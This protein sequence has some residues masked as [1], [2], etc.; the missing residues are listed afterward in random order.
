MRR[1]LVMFFALGVLSVALGD[2]GDGNVYVIPV[3]GVIDRGLATFIIRTIGEAERDG[4]LAALLDI[5]TPG[6]RVDSAVEIKDA[7]FDA[8]I[9]IVAYVDREA[10]SAGAMIA[11]SAK[12][13]FIASGG[14]IGD[15]EPQPTTEKTVSYIR[16]VMASIAERNGRPKEILEAMVDKDIE[17]EGITEKGKLLTLTA[18]RAVELGIADKIYADIDELKANF[19]NVLGDVLK[20]RDLGGISFV[21]R[22]PNWAELVVRFLT[23]PL[24]SALLLSL[25]LLGIY[26]EFWTPGI[27]FPG[28]TGMILLA[29]FFGG[30]LI[31][32]LAGWEAVLIFVL[33]VGLLIAE[34]FFIPGFGIAGIAG[35]ACI[36]TSVFLAFPSFIQGVYTVSLGIVL[37]FI[38][39]LIAIKFIPRTRFWRRLILSSSEEKKLGYQAAPSQWES[40]LGKEGR[41]ITPLRPAGIAIIDGNRVDVVTEGGLID[42]DRSI[43]VISV[44]GSR[45]VVKEKGP[46]S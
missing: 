4:A 27:G 41:T 36:A 33:G 1:A 14:T 18:E 3:K 6:G 21:L 24:V 5:N 31:A 38:F 44:R 12:H 40:L 37:L 2:V 43:E 35:I 45:V 30:H 16:S 15:V 34:I 42:R 28:I 22:E 13:V 10:I 19:K 7:I 9:P 25:G 39:T 29:L 11:L 26:A 8:K 23:H 32:G 46:G 20:R 17:I